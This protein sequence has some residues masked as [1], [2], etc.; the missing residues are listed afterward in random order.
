MKKILF[1][2][3]SLMLLFS[4][5]EQKTKDSSPKLSDEVA[6][7]IKK[8]L[9]WADY[10]KYCGEQNLHA[11]KNFEKIKGTVVTWKGKFYAMPKDID[12]RGFAPYIMKIKMPNSKNL[13]SDITLRIR[14]DHKKIGDKLKIQ[15]EVI[16]QGKVMYRGEGI[17]D[18]VLEIDKFKYLPPQ[19]PKAVVR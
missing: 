4:C 5:S 19:K 12:R 11:A 13:L 7:K 16:F 1:L 17:A 10:H 18:H 14:H 6:T 3:I 8:K 15:D 9:S 2:L